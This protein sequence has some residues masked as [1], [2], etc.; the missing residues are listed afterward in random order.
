MT[1]EPIAIVGMACRF[2]GGITSPQSYWEFL[3]AGG[4]AV[5]EVPPERWAAY[6]AA[7]NTAALRQAIKVGA[8]LDDIAGF[9]AEFFGIAP[10]EAELMDPQQRMSLEVAWEALEHAG[11]DPRSLAGSE[12]GVFMGVCCDD[13]GRRLLEDLPRIE[14]WMG[15]GSSLCG[16]ANRVSYV[17]D[18]RGPSIVVDTA[19]SASLVAVH[20]ACQSL[21]F[22]ETSLALAGGVMLVASPSFALVLDAAG[23][24]SPDGRSKAFDASADGYGRGEGCGV[25]VLKRLSD[26]QRDGDRVL[27]VIRG[28]AVCQD[29]RTDGIMAPSMPAQQ[30]LVRKACRHA[31]IEPATLGYVEAHGT[32]TG[33][34][35]PIEVGALAAVVGADRTADQ[36]CLIGSVKTNI[37]HLEAASGVAGMIK[38]VLALEHGEI[39]A[40]VISTELNPKIPWEQSGLEVVTRHTPW[41][42]T[43]HPR[44]AGIGNYGYGGTIA[45]VVLE[46][47]PPVEHP[48]QV[49]VAQADSPRLYPLSSASKAGVRADA[50]RLADWLVAHDAPL[51]SVGHTLAHR[52]AHLDV[53][54]CVVAT[55]R[56]QLVERLRQ[57]AAG[58]EVS[59][60]SA[61]GVLRSATE[62][63]AVW[64]FS[65]H[66]AQW[67]GMGR[68]LLRDEPIFGQV[69]DDVAPIVEAELGFSPRQ[70]LLADDLGDVARIQTMIFLVQ[71]GLDR[72]WRSK[73]LRPAAVIGHSVGEVAAAVS[74]GILDAHDA[75][76]LICRR[77][78]LLRRV[79]GKGAMA[80]INR[81]FAD[82]AARLSGRRDVVAAIAAAPDSTVISGAGAAVAQVIEQWQAEED[83]V[84]HRVD[85]DVAFHSPDMDLLVPDLLSTL[86]ELTPREPQVPVYTTALADPRANPA[87]DAAYW[88]ANLR[89]PVLFSAAIDAALADGHRL[90]LEVSAHPVVS[91]SIRETLVQKRIDDAYVAFTL[92]RNQPGQAALLDNLA[93]LHCHGARVDWSVLQSAGGLVDLPT[94]TWQHRNYWVDTVAR[95]SGGVIQHDPDSHTLLGA[96]TAVQG[97]SAVVIWQTRL[98]EPTRPYPG[99]HAVLGTEVV[100]AA[101]VLTTFLGAAGTDPSVVLDE[102]DLRVPISVAVPRELQVVSQDAVLKLS[103]RLLTSRTDADEDRGWLTHATAV[104]GGAASVEPVDLAAVRHCCAEQLEPDG[105]MDRLVRIGVRGIGFPWRVVELRRGADTL[106]ARIDTVGDAGPQPNTWGSALDAA[107]SVAPMVFPGAPLLRMPGRFRTVAF[108]GAP[109]VE[110]LVIVR[111]LNSAG[112]QSDSASPEHVDVDIDVLALDGTFAARLTE[113]RFG[114]VERE[115]REELSAHPGDGLDGESDWLTLSGAE[116]DD[117]LVTAVRA[118]VATEMRVAPSELDVHRPLA[119]MGVDSLMTMVIRQRLAQRFRVTVPSTVLWD[120][121]TTRAVADYL[122][123]VLAAEQ[124]PVAS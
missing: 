104:V 65:G 39:P 90:F 51:S 99:S 82:T 73:G 98:D 112:E 89:N 52:R 66:G 113:V 34:G 72:I 111:L 9:D 93:A 56:T 76:R 48:A 25:L 70:A 2:P 23:A 120:R 122:A 64:I 6:H 21:R 41:P 22:G 1:T 118:L 28:S 13:Y 103:S 45:H 71:V 106:L 81:T 42:T 97:T 59:G 124:T 108:F 62:S 88:A 114:A 53:R 74:A 7:G 83:L 60:I 123:E 91:H 115:L 110:L 94:T 16:V 19:C 31:G 37:G 32:G 14:A 75:T 54:A 43:D 44:R 57:L 119:D 100:P 18:L 92:R 77:S 29:G 36:R 35:D 107:L 117:Y 49:T 58:H 33:L 101:V 96:R 105:V 102:I 17:L 8:Y 55:D 38:V 3:R 69:L 121:P 4:N 15:I 67:V 78:L 24:I 80:M 87:R 84:V 95:S 85:T 26:A 86:A 27:A 40:T 79:T 46:E 30:H 50:E 109:P 20:Q 68:D 11:I 116:L 61:A 47:A 63:D 12:A 10:R 5:R